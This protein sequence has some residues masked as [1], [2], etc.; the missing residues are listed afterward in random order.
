[1]F[2][3]VPK[4]L[5][6]CLWWASRAPPLEASAVSVGPLEDTGLLLALSSCWQEGNLRIS[7]KSSKHE[8]RPGVG[9]G[10]RYMNGLLACYR[11]LS[12][13]FF[14]FKEKKK[15]V[16][17]WSCSAVDYWCST[18]LLSHFPMRQT[19]PFNYRP[20]SLFLLGD[21]G[22]L[23]TLCLRLALKYWRHNSWARQ[24][25]VHRADSSWWCED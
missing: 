14:C 13:P 7:N 21:I 4:E 15:G 2:W 9:Q 20:L 12:Q 1:M 22:L 19:Q 25:G 17:T 18:D 10:H 8:A 5:F 3:F 24:A 6:L 11:F 16:P 23:Y